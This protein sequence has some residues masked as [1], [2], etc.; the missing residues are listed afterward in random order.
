MQKRVVFLLLLALVSAL[1]AGS[2]MRSRVTPATFAVGC[3]DFVAADSTAGSLESAPVVL[4]GAVYLPEELLLAVPGVGRK[5]L[6]QLSCRMLEG[7]RLYPLESSA[8]QLG[9]GVKRAGG[10]FSLCCGENTD[11][12]PALE[13]KGRAIGAQPV[14]DT[15]AGVFQPQLVVD[16]YVTYTYDQM[17]EDI[18]QLTARY[19]GLVSAY[20][21]G[22]SLEGREL[23]VVTLGYGEKEVL[24]NASIHGCEYF[25]T[26]F[27]MFLIDRY[28]YAFAAGEEFAGGDPGELLGQ[29]KFV[30][31]VM[32]N[33]DGVNIAQFGLSASSNYRQLLTMDM[34]DTGWW[35]WKA[36]SAGVDINRN[37]PLN[38]WQANYQYRP[39]ARYYFG[40]E[41]ASEPETRAM[42]QLLE[43][44]PF[45]VFVDLHL[46]GEQ[47]DWIDSMSLERQEQYRPLAQKLMDAFGYSD[48]GVEDVSSFGGYLV[49]YARNT[50]GM[51]AVLIEMTDI[52]RCPAVFFDSQT[53]DL[54]CLLYILGEQ[55]VGDGV[56]PAGYRVWVN[57]RPL[58]FTG[59]RSRERMLC[60]EQT[61]A[62]LQALGAE[63]SLEGDRLL[64]RRAGESW[65]LPLPD[66]LPLRAVPA[67]LGEQLLDLREL[68]YC[69]GA[70]CRLSESGATIF[71]ELLD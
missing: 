50:Y 53:R 25:S 57:G 23:M 56:E 24:L 51:P 19:P 15:G 34:Q 38:W 42:M 47:I 71:V 61:E 45:H 8:E 67:Q 22:Q 49:N 17:L 21:M 58:I 39:G 63:A 9:L 46:Y 69:L 7:Q 12:L 52:W 44:I 28:A 70:S 2:G 4:E 64:L 29:V 41:A 1:A 48:W 62:L 6:S 68:L 16:P 5:D 10:V 37:F 36:N 35:G 27:A 13:A 32:L 54:W 3:C 43:N 30:F 33:P 14:F 40:P 55:A 59:E 11:S 18:E 20:S 65:E 66:S 31:S 60:Q 26:A